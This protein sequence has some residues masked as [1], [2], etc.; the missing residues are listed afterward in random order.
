MV[1]YTESSLTRSEV[2]NGL[3]TAVPGQTQQQIAMD[4]IKRGK[5]LRNTDIEGAYVSVKQI[6]DTL[7]RA[8]LKA[9]D[10]EE[11]QL[12]VI[13]RSSGIKPVLQAIPFLTFN[14]KAR[15]RYVTYVFAD[16]FVTISRDGIYNIQPAILRDL[17]I[18]ATI[19]NGLK[20]N[21]NNLLTNQ[22]LE[23]ILMNIYCEMFFRVIN[24][25]YSIA[26]DKQLSEKAKYL[27]NRFFLHN[28]F[29]SIDSPENID[30]L[31]MKHMKEGVLDDVSVEEIKGLYNNAMP[32]NIS[33]FLE[34]LKGISP[35]M[36]TLAMGLFMTEW[37]TYFYDPSL[38]AIDNIEYL[39]FTTLVLLSGNNIVNISASDIVKETKNIKSYRGELMKLL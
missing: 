32:Q 6:T 4:N 14:D 15:N 24:R 8:A 18:A 2:F 37:D 34:I 22:Y 17:I 20:R 19:S 39:I 25:M 7:T 9:Y 21:Y 33:A 3:N 36:R 12:V 27:I 23:E 13:E 29:S 30:R 26:A 10:S 28:V 31:S 16:R 11:V 5:L 38:L 1:V 35:R